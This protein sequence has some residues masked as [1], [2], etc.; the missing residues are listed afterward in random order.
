MFLDIIE[1]NLAKLNSFKL[2]VKCTKVEGNLL[3]SKRI[4]IKNEKGAIDLSLIEILQIVI[5]L[6]KHYSG[7]FEIN[8]KNGK[9]EIEET[10]CYLNG[11][12]LINSSTVTILGYKGS[13]GVLNS[14]CKINSK[15]GNSKLVF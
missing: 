11:I 6:N 9:A 13:L 14:K 8:S 5:G 12:H 3:K 1:F 4:S 2:V 15:Y 7:W 10:N